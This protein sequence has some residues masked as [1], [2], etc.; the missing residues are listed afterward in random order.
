MTATHIDIPQK[1][2]NWRS[3]D[4][5]TLTITGVNFSQWTFLNKDFV[6]QSIKENS[7]IV[8]CKSNQE[9]EA[10]YTQHKQL[11]SCLLYPGLEM[12]PYSGILQQTQEHI[13]RAET[14]RAYSKQNSIVFTTL[15]AL[16]L[17]FSDKDFIN[18]YFTIEK[19]EILDPQE[20]ASKLVDYGYISSSICD[21]PGTF[22]QKGEIFDIYPLGSKPIRIHYFDELIENIF[23][24]NTETNL[25]I[26]TQ[27]LNQVR[28][29]QSFNILTKKEN[30]INFRD[31]LP[32]VQPQFKSKNDIKKLMLEKLNNN[33][34]FDNY[35]NYFSLFFNDPISF[36]E[37]I[38]LNH[39]HVI[40]LD[41]DKVIEESEFFRNEISR[42]YELE[43][44]HDTDLLPE[45]DSIYN[46]KLFDEAV[47]LKA[48]NI[49]EVD[50]SIDFNLKAS[51]QYSLQDNNVYFK[52][53]LETNVFHNKSDE[54]LYILK[55]ISQ[56]KY[57]KVFVTYHNEKSKLQ[58]EHLLSFHKDLKVNYIF[59]PNING[60]Y[61]KNNNILVLSETDFYKN[62]IRKT[63]S[64]QSSNN[65]LFAEQ[66]STLKNGD[67][68]V[69]KD[70]GVGIYNGLITM[71]LNGQ[72]SDFVE[73]HFKDDDKVYVP[74]F[75]LDLI[76]KHAD[77][78]SKVTL[79][80]LKSKKFEN[81][82]NKA[83]SSIKKLAFDLLELQAKRKLSKG[84]A[85]SEPSTLYQQFCDEFPFEETPDQLKAINDILDDLQN[86]SPMDRLIC[87]D[88]G[89]GK[90]EIA[91]RAAFKAVEDKKQV[92]VL[93]PTT[94][95][96]FQ[97]Y[98]SFIKRFSNFGINIDYLSRFKSTKESNETLENIKEGKVDIV[99][100][101]HKLLS[102]KIIY[103]DLGLVIVDEEHR[104]GVG[105]KEKLKHLKENLDFLTMTATPIPRTLQLSFL[106]I[107]DFSLIKS[108]PPKRKA[109]KTFI[110]K[111]DAATFKS[112]IERELSRGGQVFIVHNR[113]RDIESFASKV[114]DLVPNAKIV[115]GHGQMAERELE[116]KLLS[117]YRGDYNILI[118]TTIIESGIDIPNAN[119]MIID[120]ADTYGLAQLH[121]LRG[122]IGRSDRKAYAYFTIPNTYKI[123]DV[124]AKR[125]QALQKYADMGA[126]FSIATS[127]LEIRGAGDI[128]G[129]DQSGHINNIGLEL[130]MSLLEE[131]IAEI[132][133]QHKTHHSKVEVQ[134]PYSCFIPE[135]YISDSAI[136]LK[137]YKRLSNANSNESIDSI[138]S[139][140]EDIYG[141]F[142]E[143]LD[144]LTR[145]L[146]IKLNMANSG[147]K[148]LKVG[149]KNIII[150]FD[151]NIINSDSKYQSKLVDYFIKRPR[152]FKLHPDFS[153][154]HQ[155]SD[156][157]TLEKL[158]LFCQK[159]IDEIVA[160]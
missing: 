76:Q 110:V 48:L 132:K 58:L 19:D 112:A 31:K 90:T 73:I 16:A 47:N 141:I 152:L 100:G 60:F 143:Q 30:I 11:Y 10:L 20:L 113:V 3:A 57:D 52:N 89:F 124:A 147:I 160:S 120:R 67:Y 78:D 32:Y 25:T 122:R 115:I 138:S 39:D 37:H 148:T 70:Y 84:F 121:Q 15:E 27:E 103:H 158:E 111:D 118:A 33:Y 8:I 22:N 79:S 54:I 17:K 68:I 88:V 139:E 61:L 46:F 51:I 116:K 66:L 23:H 149:K 5:S 4:N 86:E 12:G 114:Q 145:L 43:S 53:I 95:L 104:F 117:F 45:P 63:K 97:H 42:I 72:S 34:L 105:H 56:K 38:K 133:G 130:Y 62:K 107:R 96:A 82:K 13:F 154:T 87:G 81:Q 92:V 98:H 77:K 142:P 140:I 1:L 49:C 2:N 65:D 18:N 144:N 155:S 153:V 126:G 55:S 44:S 108:A 35:I 101:T 109:I 80:D 131:A 134:T 106:G 151:Q 40:F 125:L 59:W 85:Y 157:I 69:H 135:S 123:S 93:V 159:L 7:L 94:V 129:A 128:L 41:K 24:I 9:A 50:I 119:T 99:I 156:L 150:Y 29:Y 136:R 21:E 75:K 14:F 36:F 83:K 6:D 71:D 74:V 146:K 102:D 137:F 91:M 64:T 28:I 127:D 26:K